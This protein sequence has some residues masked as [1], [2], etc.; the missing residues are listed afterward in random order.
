[1]D[2][3]SNHHLAPVIYIAE[4]PEQ[5]INYKWDS[6]TNGLNRNVVILEPSQIRTLAEGKKHFYLPYDLTPGEVLIRHPYNQG[7]ILATDAEEEYLTASAEG[8]LLIARCL[9]ATKIVYKKSNIAEFTR[10]ID[11]NNSLKYKAVEMNLNIKQAKE[12]KLLNR[13]SVTREFPM[14]KFTAEQFAKA[15]SIAEERGLM[16]S[17]DI[18]SLLDARDPDLGSPMT[19]QIVNVEI[20]S[21]LNKVLDIAFTLNAVPLFHLNSNTRIATQKKLELNIEWD[22]CF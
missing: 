8:I 9:G 18:R 1:M 12:Q 14:Q 6:R 15:K 10:E 19:N 22:I 5:A 20:S 17:R 4:S 21:S 13:I 7:Y 11:S 3:N 2:N 16:M